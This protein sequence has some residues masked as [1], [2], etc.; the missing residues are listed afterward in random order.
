MPLP[1][2]HSVYLVLKERLRDGV[3]DERVPGEL[4]LM[5]EF[6]VSRATVRKALENLALEGL[7]ERSAG[8][9]TRRLPPAG[10]ASRSVPPATKMT[11]L[12]DNLITASLDTTVKVVEHDYVAATE[13]V[14]DMLQIPP[15]SQVL[16]AVRVRSTKAGPVSCITTWVPREFAGN[17]GRRQL[18]RKAMLVLI[19]E[20]GVE[21]GRARQSI[22]A[23]QADATVAGLLGMPLGSALLSVNRLVYDVNDRPVLWLQGLYCPDRYEYEMELSRVGDIDAKVWVSKDF[24]AYMR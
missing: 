2:Y 13:P 17:L 8:R 14:A 24:N 16:R 4:E 5:E 20:S 11:G 15:R 21:I 12:L 1:K 6:A 3:Y 18:G 10:A 7:I 9:G 22:S 19:E 23:R